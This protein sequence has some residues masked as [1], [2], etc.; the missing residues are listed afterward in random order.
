MQ[1]PAAI[2]AQMRRRCKVDTSQY[3]DANALIDLNTLKDSFWS[4]VVTN[5]PESYNWDSWKV[6]DTTLLSEYAMPTVAYDTAWAKKLKSIA[7][8][9][10]GET[11]TTTGLFQYIDAR[12][13]NPNTLDHEWNYYVENQ[14]TDDPIYFVADNSYFIAPSFRIANQADR[15]KLTW[16]RKI[17]DY[18]LTTTE[19]AMKIPV[20]QQQALVFWLMIDWYFNKWVDDNTINNAESRWE[21]K[22][23]EAIDQLSNRVESPT[24]FELPNE[25]VNDDYINLTRA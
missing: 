24:T 22:K 18:T 23:Q 14:S 16:I 6:D 15:I 2:I 5:T 7:L 25:V 17:P 3:S 19:S 12:E 20:D 10:N 21:R 13:V 4:E 1:T 9:Y 11:Y 8:N